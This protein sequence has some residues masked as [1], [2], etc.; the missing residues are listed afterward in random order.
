MRF[1]ED[2]DMR[3]DASSFRK[4]LLRD[5]GYSVGRLD[6]R[7]KN[8]D[9]MAG[10]QYS[11]TDVS[12]EGFMSAYVTAIHTWFADIGVEMD[13]LYQSGDSDVY[14][15]WKHP[16][17]WKGNDF[18]YVNTVP[19]IARAQRYNKDFEVYVSCGLYDL[20]TPCFTAENFM[21]DNSVDMDRVVFSEFE[22]GH[23]MY[24]HQPSFDRFLKEVRE[25]ILND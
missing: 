10:G 2:F 12:S 15:S 5:E 16:T 24:N 25:F 9:Y 3:V 7:Y 19:H 22:A 18:G 11:D 6:S 17:Q 13:M 20:A 4:E 23:M 1:V 8:T 14:F 21:Y